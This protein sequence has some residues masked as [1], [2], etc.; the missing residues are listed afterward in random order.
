MH[1]CPPVEQL[2]EWL[3]EQR[4]VPQAVAAHVEQCA[5]CQRLLE[6]LTG[7][8]PVAAASPPTPGGPD[9]FLRVLAN[10]QPVGGRN[11][12]DP[13]DRST[14]GGARQGATPGGLP[15]LAGYEIVAELGRGGMGVVYK[16]RQVKLGRI[17]AVKVIRK[18]RL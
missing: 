12:P 16:A 17:V 18:E 8:D 9:P 14:L 10:H 11:L 5:A 4:E 3:A 13:S 2:R 15:T 6:A 1:S 7:G